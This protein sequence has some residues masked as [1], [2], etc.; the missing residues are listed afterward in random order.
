MILTRM[1]GTLIPQMDDDV[2]FVEEIDN[3]DLLEDEADDD[4]VADIIANNV[5]THYEL[6][7]KE[8][9]IEDEYM[10]VIQNL[11]DVAPNGEI[12]NDPGNDPH[13]PNERIG[14][15]VPYNHN[16]NI[17]MDP[18]DEDGS[19]MHNQITMAVK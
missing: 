9:P 1:D 8:P 10:N 5:A 11:G 12:T 18:N 15:I 3:E 19:S 4:D 14:V 2:S 7:V 13:E 16:E 6:L 17:I